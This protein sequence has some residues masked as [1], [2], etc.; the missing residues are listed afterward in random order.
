M[1]TVKQ[2][3]SKKD[4]PSFIKKH[5]IFKT[6]KTI[7]KIFPEIGL[8][9]SEK[10]VNID[11]SQE[12]KETAKDLLGYMKYRLSY[13]SN[14]NSDLIKILDKS[15]VEKDG[16]IS[17]NLSKE[18]VDKNGKVVFKRGEGVF[19]VYNK[20]QKQACNYN[21]PAL[22]TIG[23]FKKFSAVNIPN[24]KHTIHFSSDGAEGLWD[25]AT[26]SMRGIE[27]C[28]GWGKPQS[29]SLIGSMVDPFV[30]IIYLSSGT[31][32]S[33]GSK[34]LRRCV[35]RFV[36]NKKDKKPNLFIEQM[37]PE[38][39]KAIMDQF[40]LFLKEKTKNKFPIRVYDHNYF[41]NNMVIPTSEVVSKLDMD[42]RSYRDA[43]IDY[44][45]EDEDEDD[46]VD[47]VSDIEEKIANSVS[48]SCRKIK[49]ADIPEEYKDNFREIK[50][51][52][53]YGDLQESVAD[54]ISWSYRDYMS[55]SDLLKDVS[56]IKKNLNSMLKSIVQKNMLGKSS[57]TKDIT[58][59]IVDEASKK[60]IP[61]LDK[62][63]KTKK[64]QKYPEI[65]SK[66]L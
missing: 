3:F 64:P 63:F 29:K 15:I 26:I 2:I 50:N 27:S 10:I 36:V 52:N 28:Q 16:K 13:Y 39:N 46:M 41:G 56:A 6:V 21:L 47:L 18:V 43:E 37:Y 22:D 24:A 14:A 42:D 19:K 31:K 65:Y 1:P 54:F 51:N 33:H 35:V 8:P 34:M 30:G 40:I 23:Q 38:Y 9:N 53:Y 5:K 32:T 12:I 62:P 48:S 25:I 57:K 55:K 58:Q 60:I 66:Y 20:I 44:D 59:K 17:L 7:K 49:L 61:L 11:N 4:F 45:D